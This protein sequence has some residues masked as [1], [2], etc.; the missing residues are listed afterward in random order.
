MTDIKEDA[1]HGKVG[2]NFNDKLSLNAG[3]TN[4]KDSGGGDK[5]ADQLSAQLGYNVS[6]NTMAFIQYR[7]IKLGD[8]GKSPVG[9]VSQNQG[10]AGNEDSMQRLLVG[11][12]TG[13]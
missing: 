10:I 2:Y 13:F 4:I 12:W 11:T 7:Y 6:K 9:F 1:I 5:K 3:W 8:A